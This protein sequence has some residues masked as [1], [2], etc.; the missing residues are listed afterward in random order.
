[1]SSVRQSSQSALQ[2]HNS[3][4]VNSDEIH[5]TYDHDDT[6][7]KPLPKKSSLVEKVCKFMSVTHG[8]I[9]TSFVPL[10]QQHFRNS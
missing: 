3:T 1:M 6:S 5:I 2:I 4:V 8:D 7:S 9:F 10:C